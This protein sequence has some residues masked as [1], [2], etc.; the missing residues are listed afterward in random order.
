MPR[1]SDDARVDYTDLQ[2]SVGVG[3]VLPGSLNH[4]DGGKQAG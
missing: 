3:A 2:D 4:A 1:L